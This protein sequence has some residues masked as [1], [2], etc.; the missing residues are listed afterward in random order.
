MLKKALPKILR[1]QIFLKIVLK[2]VFEY[3]DDSTVNHISGT[4]AHVCKG[5][6]KSMRRKL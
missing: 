3:A 5:N 2:Y 1:G 4:L 6:P